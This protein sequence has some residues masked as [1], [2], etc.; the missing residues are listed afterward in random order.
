MEY[1]LKKCSIDHN[2]FFKVDVEGY[3]E[4]LIR[5]IIPLKKNRLISFITELQSDFGSLAYLQEISE[6][7]Y[8][9]DLYYCPNPTR[10]KLILPEH[11]KMFIDQD[12]KN[13]KFGYTDL[14]LLDKNTP[15]A[16]IL[17]NKFGR[18]KEKKGEMVL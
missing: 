7:F 16:D 2:L 3:D 13:R 15:D 17:I 6:H 4:T 5:S 9:F 18:L 12:L 11:F 1:Y 14:F 10:F 8:I